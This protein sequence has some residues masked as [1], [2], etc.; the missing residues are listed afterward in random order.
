MQYIASLLPII[1]YI[2]VVYEIDH[3]ALVNKHRLLL[4][5]G[6]GMLTALVCSGP[7]LSV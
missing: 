3:F 4:L 7:S 5:V 6:C 1:I 2:L